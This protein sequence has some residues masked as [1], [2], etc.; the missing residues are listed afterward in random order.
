MQQERVGIAQQ[1]TYLGVVTSLIVGMFRVEVVKGSTY[2]NKTSGRIRQ[3]IETAFPTTRPAVQMEGRYGRVFTMCQC[4]GVID[5]WPKAKVG[6]MS[7]IEVPAEGVARPRW[8]NAKY[9][10]ERTQEGGSGRIPEIHGNIG[11]PRTSWL[12]GNEATGVVGGTSEPFLGDLAEPVRRRGGGAGQEERGKVEPRIR[13]PIPPRRALRH[14]KRLPNARDG[15]K[16][17]PADQV[18]LDSCTDR[19]LMD[20]RNDSL[21]ETTEGGNHSPLAL[22]LKELCKY[23]LLLNA[24][25]LGVSRRVG[26]QATGDV[27]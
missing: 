4:S 10:A 22:I 26:G 1:T 5:E 24:S 19:K 2:H 6:Q 13:L 9:C 23:R 11:L 27:G 18:Y 25:S 15:L 12:K 16:R 7:P 8:Y 20:F 17:S 21:Q 3:N 14:A